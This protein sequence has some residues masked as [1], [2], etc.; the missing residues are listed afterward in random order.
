MIVIRAVLF[1]FLF[2]ICTSLICIL[3]LPAT[4]MDHKAVLHVS[5]FFANMVYILEK[6]VLGL[7]YEIRGIEH[8]PKEGA[9]I[10]ASKH[11]SRY[12]TFKLY[13]LFDDPAIVLKKELTKIPLWGKF[14]ARMNPIA[15]DRSAGKEAMAQVVEGAK[16]TEK[17]GRALIIYPQGTR[18]LL[19]Q[20][21]E[22]KPYKH[23]VIRIYE[24]TN[25]PIIPLALNSG[26]FW[27][28]KGWMKYPGKVI[29]QFL[30]PIPSGQPADE[31]RKQLQTSIEQHSLALQDEARKTYKHIN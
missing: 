19:D 13:K 16:R 22:D 6:Y 10:V 3:A 29:F 31:V 8:L 7:E 15:I 14:L 1:N 5:R 2:Y 18:V 11:Q 30:P 24:E 23:G 12:E 4:L 20:T 27:P 17:E 9:Y 28:R 25:M 26:Q 21:I